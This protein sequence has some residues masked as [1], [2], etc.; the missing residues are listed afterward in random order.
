[1]DIDYSYYYENEDYL[2]TFLYLR[3]KVMNADE[4]TNP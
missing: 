4:E 2:Y 3:Q 1:M